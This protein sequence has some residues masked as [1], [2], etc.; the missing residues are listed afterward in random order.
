MKPSYFDLSI[1]QRKTYGN[2]CGLYSRLLRVPQFAFTA[3]CRQHD[4]NYSRGGGISDKTKADLDF[5]RAMLNDAWNSDRVIFY[6]LC[7]FVYFF[8]VSIF[9][10]FAFSWRRRYRTLEEILA[11]DAKK[12]ARYAKLSNSL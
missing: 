1:D 7:S 2:G 12:K 11:Y 4:F 6:M 10:V 5:L 3:S 9:G 8:G